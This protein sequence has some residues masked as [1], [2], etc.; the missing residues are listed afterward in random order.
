M[1]TSVKELLLV[2]SDAM[3]LYGKVLGTDATATTYLLNCLSDTDDCERNGQT[4][5][6]GPWAERT[7]AS[8]ADP[9]GTM[10]IVITEAQ[11][12][13]KWFYSLHCKMS[14][15]I[16]QKCIMENRPAEETS[17]PSTLKGESKLREIYGPTFEYGRITLTAGLENLRDEYPTRS[18][19]STASAS[20]DEHSTTRET[21][22]SSTEAPGESN[23]ASERGKSLATVFA[24]LLVALIL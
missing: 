3:T 24:G 7:L 19:T 22:A 23:H 12:S 9:T 16:A 10:D 2:P 1:S 13:T 6:L 17:A 21:G 15:S 8:G 18:A 14:R 11:E 5:T 4:I 20:K